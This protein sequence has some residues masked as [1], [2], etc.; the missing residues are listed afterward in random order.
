MNDITK[1]TFL[2][3]DEKVQLSILY[4]LQ[5]ST[6]RN[7]KEIR[8]LLEQHPQNCE[9]RFQGLEKEK[10]KNTAIAG[11]TGLTG[12]FFAVLGKKFGWW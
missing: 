3:A 5:E 12:G 8:K 4:D 9:A 6:H 7:I 11:T 1:E 10:L 2:A